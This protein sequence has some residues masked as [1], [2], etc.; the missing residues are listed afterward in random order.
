MNHIIID[1][2]SCTGCGLCASDCPNG[3]L[4]LQ[5]KKAV[6]KE[7]GCI[8]CGHCFAICPAAAITIEGFDVAECE[9]VISL[10]EFDSDKF[11][12][13]IKSRRSIRQFKDTAVDEE[14]VRKILE[15]GRYSPTAVNSQEVAYTI[16]DSSKADVE[17]KCVGLLKRAL[18]LASPFLKIARHIEVD[19]SFFFKGAPLVIVVSAKNPLDGGLASAYM[20]LM[21][22]TLGLGV[23]YSGFFT[24]CYKFSPTLKRMV[25]LKKG[26]KIV[27]CMVMGYPNVKYQ[28]TVPRD[29]LK[30][31]RL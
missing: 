27:S 20:E 6:A 22:N 1:T 11:L 5:N 2:Q 26:H 18:K 3:H 31:K 28:R 30:V 25:P 16:L 7:H 12:R 19:E 15:A 9:D 17:A 24:A 8:E 21:A 10:S 23:L 4:Q 29:A 13:A 14:I